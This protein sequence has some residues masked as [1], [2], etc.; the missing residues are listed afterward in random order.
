MRR[1]LEKRKEKK[2]EKRREDKNTNHFT[3]ETFWVFL[4]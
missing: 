1:T 2:E 3:V 4:C